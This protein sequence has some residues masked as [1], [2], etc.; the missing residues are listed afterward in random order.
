MS[1][2]DVNVQGEDFA[3]R[4]IKVISYDWADL[5]TKTTLRRS[6]SLL[7]YMDYERFF[8]GL[9]Q[10]STYGYRG[11]L[12]PSDAYLFFLVVEMGVIGVVVSLLPLAYFSLGRSKELTVLF[13]VM[14]LQTV[15]DTGIFYVEAYLFFAVFKY[16]KNE[17]LSV[18][19]TCK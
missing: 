2:A 4:I 11:V 17:S 16:L 18:L 1:L 14:L 10:W 3:A 8:V 9:H 19:P 5:L 12:S 15:V 13:I 7:E 6:I